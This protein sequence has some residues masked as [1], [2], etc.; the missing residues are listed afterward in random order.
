MDLL[1]LYGHY[2]RMRPWTD[3]EAL[4]IQMGHLGKRRSAAETAPGA[5]RFD[6]LLAVLD[7][8]EKAL[9]MSE[10]AAQ[11][12]ARFLPIMLLL[13][14]V[15]GIPRLSRSSISNPDGSSRI[16]CSRTPQATFR[17]A[18]KFSR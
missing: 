13:Q 6:L 3:I 8:V 7:D 14:T 2:R 1:E 11:A 12:V 18:T 15:N 5:R 4:S 9:A 17:R 10:E 16:G